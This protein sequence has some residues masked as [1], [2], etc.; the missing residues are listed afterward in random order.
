MW[1]LG[2]QASS[3]ETLTLWEAQKDRLIRCRKKESV[4]EHSHPAENRKRLVRT[5]QTDK[6]RGGRDMLSKDG[7]WRNLSEHRKKQTA[8]GTLTFW[9]HDTTEWCLLGHGG[10]SQWD[11][12]TNWRLYKEETRQNMERTWPSKVN[13]HSGEGRGMDLWGHEEK[14]R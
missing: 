9:R 7:R 6:K 8:W 5:W 11:T 1:G 13:S 10:K 2:K 4:K 12:P 3:W 14:R